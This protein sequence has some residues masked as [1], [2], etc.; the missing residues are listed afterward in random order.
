LTLAR[1]FLDGSAALSTPALTWTGGLQV[2]DGETR[3]VP[4]GPGLAV[5]GDAPHTLEARRLEIAEGAT[6]ALRADLGLQDGATV[7]NAGVLDIVGDHGLGVLCCGGPP[8]V[9]NAGTLRK[10]GGDGRAT[11]APELRNDGTVEARSG[12]LDLAGGLANLDEGSLVGGRYVVTATLALADAPVRTNVAAIVLDGPDSRIED[13]TGADALSALESNIGELTLAG[14]RTLAT[15]GDLANSGTITLGDGGTLA[16]AGGYTQTDGLTAFESR[17][18]VLVPGARAELTGGVLRGDATVAA[19]LRNAAEVDPGLGLLTVIGDYE[20]TGSG[21]L[22]ATVAGLDSHTLLG[23]T[24][25]AD[26]AGTL[27]IA[28]RDFDPEPA[29][30]IEL[31]R[32]TAESGEF[33]AVEGLEPSP[34]HSYSPPDY[35]EGGVWLRPGTVPSVSIGDATAAESGA[36]TLAVTVDPVPTRAVRVDWQTLDGSATAPSDYAASAGTLAIPHGQAGADVSV[37]IRE[38]AVD[39]PDETFGVELTG[40]AGASLGRAG[41][42]VAI[43]DDDPPVKRR[44]PPHRPPR[45]GGGPPHRPPHRPPWRHPHPQPPHRC[46]DHKRP[47][48]RLRRGRRGVRHP[49]RRLRLRGIARDRGCSHLRR[50]QVSIAL[51]KHHRCRFVKKNGRLGKRRRCRRARWVTVQGRRNWHLRTRRLRPGRYTIRTRAI[52]RAGNK[53]RKRRRARPRRVRLR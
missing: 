27:R 22:T 52:D 9:R 11:I 4:G 23:M 39:E 36:A 13:E 50:V 16:P 31:I 40:A 3:V 25:R 32:H 24:G 33:D 10:S 18:A 19:S 26:L 35:P 29:D 17:D 21:V 53:E 1:G 5:E 51:H 44:P 48:S 43:L 34:G 20:Q 47:S 41:G 42:I 45:D 14:G 28:T 2:G 46:V 37:P 49:H 15:T 38:D 7:D 12:T 6:A 30:E 8:F